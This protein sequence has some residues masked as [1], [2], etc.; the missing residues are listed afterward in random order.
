MSDCAYNPNPTT[1]EAALVGST[2]GRAVARRPTS[3]CGRRSS[4]RAHPRPRGGIAR[5]FRITAGGVRRLDDERARSVAGLERVLVDWDPAEVAEF[6][7]WLERFD[8]DLERLAGHPWPR[9]VS[10]P[11]SSP[12]HPE[13]RSGS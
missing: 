13:G 11:G 12:S 4:R 10:S 7:R 3:G 6:T 1:T 5:K 8:T 9:P 2:G